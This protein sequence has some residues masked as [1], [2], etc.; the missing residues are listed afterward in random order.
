MIFEKSSSLSIKSIEE[1][2][3]YM[4]LSP[5]E[6]KKLKKIIDLHPMRITKYYL[7]LIDKNDENDPIKRMIIPSLEELDTSGFYDTS[8]ECENTKTVGLQHKYEQTVLMLSTN[9][10]F[11]YCRFCFRKRLVGLSN[12]EI[13]HRFE[14]AVNYIKK[15]KEIN[16]VLVSGG[17]PFFLSAK[18]L[19]KF[20]QSLTRIPHIRFIRF[21]TRTPVV[22]PDRIINDSSFLGVLKKY[23]TKNKRIYVVTHFNHPREITN[24]S[25]EA[26]NKLIGSNV[27]IN[28][29]TV[30]LKGV[31]DNPD[32]LAELQNTLTSIGITPYY[33]FQCRPVK[34]VKHH[35]QV[36]LYKAYQIVE[37]AK[38]KLNG[39]SKRF[40]FI[41]SH[42]S[43][44]V[45]IVGIK[46]DNIYF[47]YHQAKK[48]KDMGRF[49]MRKLNKTGT[50][51]DDFKA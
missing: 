32:T 39:C 45:E 49:F 10:C 1:L 19:E 8:G 29:Q 16:N 24:K 6:E 12:D 2:K 15:H 37:E 26:I 22:F 25:I 7:S 36:L 44:K 5:E 34:R 13:V 40:R 3:E 4:E 51:L 27:I 48:P 23:S 50:W 28:N 30:L 38:T 11:A 17:D 18:A 9:K 31:N 14:R 46:D 43:G 35:F 41:M 47:K 42:R 21:G 33:V 20:L